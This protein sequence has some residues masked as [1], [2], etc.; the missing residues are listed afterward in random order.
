MWAKRIEYADKP[1]ILLTVRDISERKEMEIENEVMNNELH[2][3]Q[4]Q[5]EVLQAALQEAQ[6]KISDLQRSLKDNQ[7]GSEDTRMALQELKTKFQ[8]AQAKFQNAQMKIKKLG[9]M[10]PVCSSCKKIRDDDGFWRELDDFISNPAN[11]ELLQG[12]CPDCET[13]VTVTTEN[14]NSR[15]E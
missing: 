2:D 11:L 6:Q 8:V 1:A 4:H 14:A 3:A 12:V 13:P 10:I 15:L 7:T 9:K 5:A